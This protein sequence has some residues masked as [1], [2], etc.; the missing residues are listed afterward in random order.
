MIAKLEK[1][2]ELDHRAIEQRFLEMLPGIRNV[3]GFA[4]RRQHHARRDDLIAEVIANAF[5]ASHR[6]ACRGRIDRAFPSA[7]AW[8][9]V[10]QVVEGRRTGN[11]LNSKDLL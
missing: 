5:V 11:Q 8:F 6:L 1:P 10:K 3:A 9:A 4:F 2:P 7:L